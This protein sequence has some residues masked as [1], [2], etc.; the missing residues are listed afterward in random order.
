[1]A[2]KLEFEGA[3]EGLTE[4]VRQTRDAV[5]SLRDSVAEV[6]TE[7]KKQATE[8]VKSQQTF[9]A[10]IEVT[11]NTL[12]KVQAAAEKGGTAKLGKDLNEAS[13]SAEKFGDAIDSAGD[14]SI[15]TLKKVTEEAKKTAAAQGIQV[16]QIDAQRKGYLDLLVKV[17]ALTKEEG[18]LSQEAIELTEALEGQGT[19]IA[20]GDEKV[21]SLRARF[22]EAKNEAAAMVE[23]FGR[24]SPEA[25]AALQRAA[26]LKDELGDLNDTL[27]ALNP[28]AKFQAFGQTLTAVAGGFTAVQ[29]ALGLFGDESEEVQKG[30]LKIQSALAI[31]QGLQAFFGGLGDG[32]KNIRALLGAT[33][34]ATTAAT[35]ASKADAVAKGAQAAATTAVGTASAAAATGVRAFVAS[36]LASPLAPIIIGLTAVGAAFALLGDDAEEAD[37]KVEGLFDTLD[38]VEKL[39]M[40]NIDARIQRNRLAEEQQLVGIENEKERAKITAA[41][42]NEELRLLRQKAELLAEN[43][44]A[45][46]LEL[47]KAQKNLNIGS[48]EFKAI[49][50]RADASRLAARDAQDDVANAGI[51]AAT[52]QKELRLK[53]REEELKSAEERK[54]IREKLAK[55][56]EAIEQRLAARVAQAEA[57]GASPRR[58]LE[59]QREQNQKEIDELQRD[60]LRKVAAIEIAGKLSVEAFNNLSEQELNARADALIEQGKVEL[61]IEQQTQFDI[62]R[63][64]S[65]E[66]YNKQSAELTRQETE[67]RIALIVDSSERELV[68]FNVKLE[69]E[70][71]ALREAGAAEEDIVRAQ[72]AQRATFSRERLLKDLKLE[73][74]ATIA[75]IEAQQRGAETEAQFRQRIELEKLAAQEAFALKRL[76]AIKEDATKEGDVTRAELE[77]LITGIK[78]QREALLADP[79]KSDIFAL[80]GLNLTEA[81]KQEAIQGLQQIGQA[82]ESIVNT[83]LQARARELEEQIA[84]TDAIIEDAQRRRDELFQQ[85]E[86]EQRDRDAGL[87]NNV[88]SVKAAIEETRKAEAKAAEDKKRIVAER[89]K[90]AK[91]QALADSITQASSLIT[92]GASLFAD[93]A[94]KGPVGIIVAVATIAGMIASFLALKSK[95]QAATSQ[96]FE[97]GGLARSPQH[98]GQ[99]RVVHGPSHADGGLGVYNEKTGERQFEVEGG[100][101]LFV[102]NRR[103]TKKNI[104]ILQAVNEND[105]VK[106]ARLAMSMVPH[107]E[108]LAPSPSVVKSIVREKERI[109]HATTVMGVSSNERL[110]KKVE[111]LTGEVKAFRAQEGKRPKRRELPDGTVEYEEGNVIT[112]IKPRKRA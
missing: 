27:D 18:K 15:N 85:L 36:L 90:L 67:T 105:M 57:Q 25:Q 26:T 107:P 82:V 21:K 31:T 68:A 111:E 9:N 51:K 79:P 86:A 22:A 3:G 73:E 37:Q 46:D 88:D 41:T 62:L 8:G 65:Q 17:G 42:T 33:T 5:V 70:A 100:E 81:Q 16:K 52:L 39:D 84:N 50:D 63:L 53:I 93:G 12:G 14:E 71:E 61:P 66:E 1:M 23:Q 91:Q 2:I 4:F 24:F 6:N 59:I 78:Q 99:M 34:A 56:I 7:V 10:A 55:D 69:K 101:G 76:E 77:K 38:A 95:A 29:G 13:V 64:Q 83:S 92:A 89:Q 102:I 97:Q 45:R 30:L 43:S 47:D 94:T 104:E 87:A 103:S 44:R 72:D 60:A 20:G 32:L 112:R 110:E 109:V 74:D 49:R 75:R 19:A 40:K 48:E 11:A 108:D 35:A 58:K 80:L 98:M 106:T 54:A 96:T 28:D